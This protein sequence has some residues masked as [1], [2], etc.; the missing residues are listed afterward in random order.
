[1]W[2]LLLRPIV[3]PHT[4]AINYG[5]DYPTFY[6]NIGTHV[7]LI[8]SS[9]LVPFSNTTLTKLNDTTTRQSSEQQNFNM[10]ALSVTDT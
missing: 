9:I 10:S 6:L 5:E 1:M 3:A 7:V 2:L 4:L 8:L